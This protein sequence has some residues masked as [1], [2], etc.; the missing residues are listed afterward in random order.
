MQGFT[1]PLYFPQPYSRLC[2]YLSFILHGFACSVCIALSFKTPIFLLTVALLC[3]NFWCA[4]ASLRKLHL[5][6]ISI[7]LRDTDEWL[8]LCQE[9][10]LKT[11]SMYRAPFCSAELII[12]FL[13][14]ND[15]AKWVISLAPDN[16][17]R[18]QRRRLFVR[19]RYPIS[20]SR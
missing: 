13:R 16:T 12:L 20:Y 5:N 7:L 14:D 1:A 17:S 11:A 9:Q 15:G 4:E 6:L 18:E 19:L 8:I 3:M 10:V 2:H